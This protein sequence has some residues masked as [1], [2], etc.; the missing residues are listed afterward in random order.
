MEGVMNELA[1]R[2]RDQAIDVLT[3]RLTFERT[4]VRLYDRVL[5]RIRASG[6][7]DVA[8]LHDPMTT[9]RDQEKE[10]EEWLEAR[11]RE[12]GGSA[13]AMTARAHLAQT[14]SRG[15]EAVIFDDRAT[16]P[17]LL[18]A[19]LTAE[20]VD[21]ARWDLLVALADEANDHRLK[22]EL[23]RRLHEEEDHLVLLQRALARFARREL[24]S[25]GGL[26]QSIV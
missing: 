8:W 20:L 22:K 23:K 4:A 14:E 3:E 16:V 12:S 10:H 5:E 21:N 1:K 2:N 7:P 11:I 25:S 24:M 26:F 13:H 6:D 19:L 18:H 17:Q 15:I 9:H